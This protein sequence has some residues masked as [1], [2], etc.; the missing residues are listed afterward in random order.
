VS[1]PSLG[2]GAIRVAGPHHADHRSESALI[3]ASSR[4]PPPMLL[5]EDKLHS[6]AAPSPSPSSRFIV[7]LNMPGKKLLIL[8]THVPSLTLR[9]CALLHGF[10]HVHLHLCYFGTKGL[11]FVW[12]TPAEAFAP[13]SDYGGGGE[14]ISIVNQFVSSCCYRYDCGGC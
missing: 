5:K 8:C 13:R 10:D 9:I 6:L 12:A 3:A 7:P 1:P 14:G 11:P 4:T 2:G